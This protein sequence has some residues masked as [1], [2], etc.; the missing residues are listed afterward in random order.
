MSDDSDLLSCSRD[1]KAP[2]CVD[3]EAHSLCG[4]ERTAAWITPLGTYGGAFCI[5]GPSPDIECC[6]ARFC[7]AYRIAEGRLEMERS[8]YGRALAGFDGS[9]TVDLIVTARVG[10]GDTRGQSIQFEGSD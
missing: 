10:Q 2:R 5:H 1:L 6:P 8:T 7:R 9:R 4:K 3:G